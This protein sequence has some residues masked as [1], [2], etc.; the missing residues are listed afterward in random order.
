MRRPR[1]KDSNGS[2]FRR[3]SSRQWRAEAWLRLPDGWDMAWSGPAGDGRY[4]TVAWCAGVSVLGHPTAEA[5]A[6]ALALINAHGCGHDCW[7]DH[8]LIDLAE[9]EAIAPGVEWRRL[10]ARRAHLQACPTCDWVFA[11]RGPRAAESRHHRRL[12]RVRRGA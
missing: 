7:G 2:Q 3:S 12:R 10:W 11:G 4:A 8:E 9:P 1:P 5:A 6:S